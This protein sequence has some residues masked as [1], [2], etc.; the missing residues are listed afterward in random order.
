MM[1]LFSEM[2]SADRYGSSGTIAVLPLG[3][4]E[5]HGPHLPLGTDGYIVEGLLDSVASHLLNQDVTV[6]RLPLLWLGASEEHLG[7][8]G[9]LS[10]SGEQIIA[11][12][13]TLGEG[14]AVT[15]V[16]RLLFF[17]GHGGN[18]APANIAALRLR[19]SSAMLVANLHWLDLGLPEDLVAPTAV[20]ID[21][22]GGWVET[23]MLMHLR[24]DLVASEHIRPQPARPPSPFLFPMGPVAWGWETKDLSGSDCVGRPDLAQAGIG[25]RLFTH[26]SKALAHLLEELAVAPWPP[27]YKAQS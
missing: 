5:A 19:R 1:R 24:R 15:G 22:H 20:T 6:L 12:L 9:T 8:P 7:T 2:S 16:S 26:T 10:L 13:T 21:V 14:L 4:L 23:S 11:T 27:D 17:N 25:Q 18:I 3:S